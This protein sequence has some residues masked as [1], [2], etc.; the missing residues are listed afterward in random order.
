MMTGFDFK[1]NQMRGMMYCPYSFQVKDVWNFPKDTALMKKLGWQRF[2][3]YYQPLLN[4]RN[5]IWAIAERS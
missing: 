2:K 5:T 3:E 1:R 4:A